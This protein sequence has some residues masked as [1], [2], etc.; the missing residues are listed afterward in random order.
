[1]A[2][3]E[4]HLKQAKIAVQLAFIEPDRIKSAK[5]QLL[6]IEHSEKAENVKIKQHY[7]PRVR[8]DGD[9]V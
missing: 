6:A 7:S 8:D 9:H 5:F 1:M 2:T 3:Q 4:Y